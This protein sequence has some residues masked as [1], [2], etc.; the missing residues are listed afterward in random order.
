VNISNYLRLVGILLGFSFS[1]S[2]F[3]AECVAIPPGLVGWWSGDEHARDISGK[4]NYGNV[5]DLSYSTG[6]VGSTFSFNGTTARVKMPPS[7][8]LNVRS[9]TFVA[10]INPSDETYR[11]IILYQQDNDYMG[12]LFWTGHV[13]GGGP[14]SLYANLRE[15]PWDATKVIQVADVIAMNQWNFVALTYDYDS[16]FARLYVNGE[17][18]QEANFG[19]LQ[20]RT[21]APLY[22]GHSP[23]TTADALSSR[24]F[25]GSI[26]EVQI[27]NRA[28]SQEELQQIYSSSSAGICKRDELPIPLQQATA[29]FSQTNGDFAVGYAIDGNSIDNLG[30]G[31]SPVGTNQT[32]AFE[33]VFDSGFAGGTIFNIGLIFNHLSLPGSTG[34]SLGRFRISVTS[35][36]RDSFANGLATGGDVTA[37]WTPLTILSAS[38]QLGAN[39]TILPDDS[40]L[41]SGVNAEVD[42]YEIRAGTRIAGI[43]GFRLEALQDA[44]L[45]F[46]GPG[47]EQANGNFVVSEFWVTAQPGLGPLINLQPNHASISA[48]DSTNFTVAATSSLP[49]SYQWFFNGTA[50]PGET[51]AGVSI[52]NATF[53]ASGTYA[54]EVSNA[55]GTALSAGAVLSV[56]P[57]DTSAAATLRV[58]N[59]QPTN[60]PVSD[61]QNTL[62]SGARFLAQAYVGPTAANLASVG[63][64]VPFLSGEDAGYFVPIHLVLT[65]VAQGSNVFVQVLVWEAAAGA[66]YE[67]SVQNGGQHGG[68][69]VIE[70]AT[71]GGA[72]PTPELQGLTAFSLV[73]APRI[74][75]QPSSRFAYVGQDVTLQV[76]GWGSTPLSYTW[77]HDSN[78]VSGA[79][80]SA[81][82]ITNVQIAHSGA[83]H[84]VIANAAGSIT[85]S[86]DTLTVEMPDITPPEIVITSPA[87]GST[88]D[89][90]VSLAGTISDVKGI[91]SAY[92]FR[93]GGASMSLTLVDGK[94]SVANVPLS[95]G[96]NTFRIEASDPSTNTAFAEVIVTNMASRTLA[97]AAIPPHQEGSRI[98]VPILLTSRGEVGGASFELTYNRSQVVEP[99]VVWNDV[100]QGA[101]TTFNT[102]SLGRIL[103]SFALS[104][105][106]VSSGTVQIATITFRSLSVSSTT[107]VQ[108]GLIA[109]GVFGA[110][111]NELPAVGTET[112]SGSVLVTRRKF[113][114]DNNANDR[115]DINDATII[116]RLVNLLEPR[117]PWDALLNDLN[118]NQQLDVGDVTRVLRAVV[119]LDPQPTNSP[120]SPILARSQRAFA[121][122]DSRITLIADKQKAGPGEKVNVMVNLLNVAKPV[123]G[124]SFRLHYPTNALK[125]EGSAS[126]RTGAIVPVNAAVLWNVAP[127]QIDYAAQN[128]TVYV[129]LTSDRNWT[130]N[131]GPLAQFEF[132]V[133]EGAHGQ[134]RWPLTVTAVE[135]S[136]GFD[137]IEL[138]GAELFYIGRDAIAPSF[139]ATPQFTDEGLQL[140]FG[141]ESG[142]QYRIERSSDLL[143]WEPL[144]T[145][146]GI[147]AALSVIDEDAGQPAHRFYRAVQVP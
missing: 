3:A 2:S 110:D 130:T 137:L 97:V 132:T 36:S 96:P 91:S 8:S 122:G 127:G 60:A 65:N 32:A 126:H 120:D 57:A 101:L 52:A 30:W 26:D 34:H 104:G 23:P 88:Y 50:L 72:I 89:T 105:S 51:N 125:L 74:L 31:I 61:F 66:T 47:R 111:G 119:G 140:T 135:L 46:N 25:L 14:G 44:S 81:L 15:T 147:G 106:T 128:G 27:Y 123:F 116:M 73:V 55:E 102:N 28:L 6:K 95:R 1:T 87:A 112:K 93:N 115:L 71:G 39:L 11:P 48:G 117:R 64:A 37:H 138:P 143:N 108:F 17:K 18:V 118:R 5:A 21:A 86:V 145:I 43:T 53:A 90:T 142:V 10:W 20:P 100:P 124:A 79:T 77:F 85:S 99:E 83:Y 141:T 63:P 80:S 133:Q 69:A 54:V 22:I 146:K 136:S 113:I 98:A 68:S 82:T 134:F 114:G 67:A 29:T 94:F 24:S 19:S 75:S 56:L 41:V 16:G 76:E 92:W 9:L 131:S 38:S 13:P 70:S 78:A 144:T 58:W 129:A 62:L 121:A 42:A 59:Q 12:A 109:R 35:D 139:N 40:V 107:P 103:A 4:F 7:P 33:T 45:P 49:V 84:V